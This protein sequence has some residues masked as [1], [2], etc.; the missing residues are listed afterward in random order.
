VATVDLYDSAYTHFARP[1]EVAVRAETYGEDL[2]Q[3]GWMTAAEWRSFFPLLALTPESR[4]LEVGCGSGG[5]AVDLARAIGCGIVGIDVNPAGI[6]NATVLAARA[7]VADRATFR[8]VDAGAR[9]PF[10]DASFD[11][12][13][14]ND[15]MCHLPARAQVLSEWRR[16]L[17]PGGRALYT[18]AMVV[19]GAVTNAE[20]ATRSSIGVYLFVPP[21][22]N[23]RLLREA[24]LAVERVDDVTA[25]AETIA[26]RWHDARARH[27]DALVDVEGETNFEG[28]QRFLACVHLVSRER[29]LSRFL[30]LARRPA[31]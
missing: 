6:E 23:E 24:G 21:G 27:R 22:G 14:S 11:A 25:S 3:S 26:G 19:T 29:R 28:L 4:V 31:V 16:V 10:D 8:V 30:Y 20:L 1:V 5:P 17:R 12:V 18:D 9:L 2:G 13:V 15:A 7:G